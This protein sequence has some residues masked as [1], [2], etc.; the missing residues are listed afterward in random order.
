MWL[1]VSILHGVLQLTAVGIARKV[2]HTQVHVA[3]ATVLQVVHHNVIYCWMDSS[4][5]VD[6]I[7]YRYL[8]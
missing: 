2:N 8:L 7:E 3:I 5:W 4:D 6:G 1:Y